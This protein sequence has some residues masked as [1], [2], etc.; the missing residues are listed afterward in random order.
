[1]KI[2]RKFYH[3]QS[4][5]NTSDGTIHIK[6][7]PLD[8]G[9]QIKAGETVLMK[10]EVETPRAMPYVMVEA[11]LPSGSE[12]VANDA[13]EDAIEAENSKP[14]IVGDWEQV[15]WNHQDILDDKIV[16]SA[17]ISNLASRNSPLSCEWNCPAK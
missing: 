15:W 2:S 5:A 8:N 14:G 16:S 4:V 17:A 13:K 9:G 11:A 7:V 6:S 10:I 3:L 12:V 1:L